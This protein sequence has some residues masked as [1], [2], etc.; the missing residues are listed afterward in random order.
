MSELPGKDINH[1]TYDQSSNLGDSLIIFIAFWICAL[2]LCG[3]V[4]VGLWCLWGL[5]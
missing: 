3:L 1:R 2:T 5:L 4:W